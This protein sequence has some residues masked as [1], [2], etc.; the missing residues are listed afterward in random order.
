MNWKNRL[1]LCVVIMIFLLAS[2]FGCSANGD[3]PTVTPQT[4]KEA[5]P[6]RTTSPPQTEPVEPTV[7]QTEEPEPGPTLF[8]PEGEPLFNMYTMPTDW[9]RVVPLMT[10]FQVMVYEW[11]DEGMYAAGYA[12]VIMSRANNYYTNAQKIH[13]SSNI[14]EQDPGN[15]S[16]TEGSEQIFNY[17]G[18][19]N[20]LSVVLLE[21]ADG[22]LNFEIFFTPS[23]S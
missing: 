23:D 13:V 22:I 6:E 21:A 5:S 12:D 16:I 20:A 1:I 14:W 8:D 10:E 3:K 4:T 19:G 18:E 15:P 7:P 11:S 2:V 17:I 9:P